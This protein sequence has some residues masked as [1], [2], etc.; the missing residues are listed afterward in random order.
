MPEKGQIAYENRKSV[1]TKIGGVLNVS[2]I[3]D[4]KGQRRSKRLF[5]EGERFFDILALTGRRRGRGEKPQG[6]KKE[7]ALVKRAYFR[8]AVERARRTNLRE[9]KRLAK[10]PIGK[11][12]RCVA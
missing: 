12:E 1:V 6:G 10:E 9:K 2:L 3:L 11:G 8:D 7:K 5:T 4:N